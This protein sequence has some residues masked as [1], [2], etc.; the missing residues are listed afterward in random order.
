[1]SEDSSAPE[2]Q[3]EASGRQEKSDEPESNNRHIDSPKC[4]LKVELDKD[5]T[6]RVTGLQGPCADIFEGLPPIRQEYWKR[7]MTTELR[8]AIE[9]RSDQEGK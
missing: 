1:M 7:R 9:R 4:M 6:V 2:G 3:A 8:S 5:G